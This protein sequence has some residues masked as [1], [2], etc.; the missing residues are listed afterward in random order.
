MLYDISRTREIVEEWLHPADDHNSY[1][2]WTM[3]GMVGAYLSA[4]IGKPM[5]CPGWRSVLLHWVWM[6][7]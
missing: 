2:T 7:G 3:V 6:N 1:D 4:A 5:L